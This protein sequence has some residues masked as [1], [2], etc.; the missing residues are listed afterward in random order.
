MEQNREPR[1]E[2][3]LYGQLIFD[4]GVQNIQW[5]KN[6]LFN[7]RCWEN[8][9]ATCKRL[10]LD[11]FLTPDAKINSNWIKDLNVRPET[12]KIPEE[13][14]GRRLFDIS[15]SNIYFWIYIAIIYIAIYI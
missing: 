6:S 15:L 14:I 9:A 4:K 13:N 5:G 8:Q 2:P 7:K 1:N 11:Y 10:K 3:H 12:I